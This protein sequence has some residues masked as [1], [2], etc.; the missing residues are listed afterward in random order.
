[1]ST[2]MA[3]EVNVRK[4]L[5]WFEVKVYAE[6]GIAAM[7]VQDRHEMMKCCHELACHS[8]VID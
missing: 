8:G 2:K 1:M 5:L 4:S 6:E 7:H 3:G